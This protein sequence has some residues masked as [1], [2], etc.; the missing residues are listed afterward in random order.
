MR[1]CALVCRSARIHINIIMRMATKLSHT[2]TCTRRHSERITLRSRRR[3]LRSWMVQHGVG[4]RDRLS[5]H[6]KWQR[7]GMPRRKLHSFGGKLVNKSMSYKSILKTL[8]VVLCP[9]HRIYPFLLRWRCQVFVYRC[10][11]C[12]AMLLGKNKLIGF[13]LLKRNNTKTH[14]KTWPIQSTGKHAS[15]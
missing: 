10:G 1:Q 8:S 7:K 3:C 11:E 13:K 4:I 9:I 6:P 14:Q 2:H 15:T 5:Q 12:S